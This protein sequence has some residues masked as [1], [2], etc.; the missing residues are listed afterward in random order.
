MSKF[1]RIIFEN[2]KRSEGLL[3]TKEETIRDVARVTYINNEGGIYKLCYNDKFEVHCS[4]GPAWTYEIGNFYCRK[5]FRCGILHRYE[6][7]AVLTKHGES[8]AID[9]EE[10]YSESMFIMARDLNKIYGGEEL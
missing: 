2:S 1:S 7:P 5:Y 4:H 8:W 9:G 3:K 6:G 10:Y